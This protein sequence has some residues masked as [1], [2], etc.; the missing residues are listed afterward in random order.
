M[1]DRAVTP[2]VALFLVA[3]ATGLACANEPAA[4]TADT[5]TRKAAVT[6]AAP[7]RGLPQSLDDVGMRPG[8]TPPQQIVRPPDVPAS[9]HPGHFRNKVVDKPAPIAGGTAPPRVPAAYVAK[10]DEYLRQWSALQPT[11]ADLPQQEQDAR[12]AALK[13]SVIGE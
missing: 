7:S 2:T 3:M 11:I 9:Q 6:A 10:Q 8:G 4:P 5:T 1:N 12:R 13:R